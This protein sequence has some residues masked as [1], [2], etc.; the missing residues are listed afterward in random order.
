MVKIKLMG[1]KSRIAKDI[2]PIIQKC[3]DDNNLKTYIEPFVGGCNVIDKVLCEYKQGTDKNKYLIALF[4][5]LQNNGKLLPEVPRELYSEVRANYKNGEYEDWYVGNIGFLAS[6]NG[7]WF[8][9]GYSQPGYEKTKT[10]QRYRDY[11]REAKDNIESQIPYIKDIELEVKDYREITPNA[12]SIIYCDPP[13]A[14]VKQFANA[15]DFDYNVFWD[16]MREW[17]KD[18]FV[19]VSELSAPD[20]FI[21][22]WEKSV[23]RSIKS[24]DK[25]RATEKLFAYKYGKYAEYIKAN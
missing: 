13:Y 23:S 12:N 21:C 5:H 22:V 10:G 16:K 7:R 9:G 17:S 25:S 20:D 8:D 2:V 15:I 3:I 6:Y 19:L 11:Y 18:C 24:T 4:K 1:A 14:N